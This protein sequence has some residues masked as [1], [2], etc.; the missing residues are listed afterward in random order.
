MN[1]R[2]ASGRHAGLP[3]KEYCFCL[4]R[5]RLAMANAVV[6]R[7][8]KTTKIEKGKRPWTLFPA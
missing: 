6:R 1:E 3:Q 7:Q 8:R 2:K 5:N 4:F